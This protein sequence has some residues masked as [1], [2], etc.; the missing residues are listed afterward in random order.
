VAAARR[1]HSAL[2][3]SFA[4]YVVLDVWISAWRF[5]SF[6]ANA[7]DLGFMTQ[8]LWSTARGHGFLASDMSQGGTYLGEHVAPAVSVAALPYLFGDS[9]RGLFVFQTI[10]LGSAALLTYRLARAAGLER[11]TAAFAG[12]AML[13]VRPLRA[14]NVFDFRE[15]DLLVPAFLEMLIAHERGRRPWTWALALASWTVK[16]TAPLLTACFGLGLAFGERRRREGIAMFA[17]SVAAFYVL[18]V[19]L[20]SLFTGSGETVAA[21]RW[22]SSAPA[23]RPSPVS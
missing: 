2:V 1:P 23:I 14:A 8:A 5:D 21:R 22:A 12:I 15:D 10:V 4:V 19:I 3:A 17:L 9:V 20:P 7:W 6:S 11:A 18:A 16:E 13:L